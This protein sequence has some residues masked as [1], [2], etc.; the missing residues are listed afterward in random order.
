MMLDRFTQHIVDPLALMS[1]VLH[2]Q[3]YSQSSTTLPS[4]YVQSHFADNT[5]LDSGLSLTDNLIENLTNTL[6]LITQS[7]KTYLPQTNNQLRTSS[8][9]RN[10]ATVQDDRV[11]IQN[12]QG[13]QN[14]CQGNNARG[15]G[16]T[17][18]EKELHSVKLQLSSTI[19]HNKSMVV[20]I[21]LWYLDSSCSKHMMGDRSRLK[22]FMKKFIGTVRF[23]NDH[24]G[25]I[26]VYGDYVIGDS[27]ISGVY[28]VEGLGHNLFSVRQFCYFDLEVA[29]KIH[30]CYVR[31]SDGGELIKE[32]P[33][34]ERSVSPAPTVLVQINSAGTPSFTTDQDAPSL[35]HSPSSSALQ[36]PSLQQGIAA[37]YTHM[38]DNPLAPVDNDPFVNMFTTEPSSEASS[39]GDLNCVMLIALN[40]I[41]KVKLDEYD[42]VLKNK[43]RLAAKGYRQDEGIDFEESFTPDARIKAIRIFIANCMSI[44]SN[45]SHLFSPLRDPESL[46]RQRNLSEP[47]SLFDFKEVLN[48]NQNQEPPPQ[49]GLPPMKYF[50]PSMV[51]KLRN[52]IAKFEQKPYESLFEACEHYKLSIDRGPNHNMLLVT[53]INTLYNGLTLSH[54]DTI[55]AAAGGTFMQKTP[56]CP[57]VG[58]YNQETGYA[59]TGTCSLPSNTVPNPQEDLKAITTRSGVTLA[60]PSVSPSS[61]SKEVDREPEKKMDQ[62]LTRNTNNVLPLVVQPSPASTSFSNNSSSKIPEVTKDTVQPSTENIQPPV[63]QKQNIIYE[64][65]VAPKPKPTIPYPSRVNKQK[66]R[67]KD[68]NLALKFVEIFRNLHFEL[69]FADALLQMHLRV[70]L[71]LERPFLR[72]GRALIDVYGEELILRDNDEAI[73]FKEVL[74]FSDNSKSGNPTSISDPI[75]V[76]SS[77]SLTP[78]KGGDFILEEIE[79]CLTSESI[80]LR[81]DDTDLDLEGDIRLLEEL[82]KNDPSL[83]P[84]PSKEINK[85]IEAL[86]LVIPDWNLPF[87]LMCKASDFAIGAILGQR[88]MKHF[89]PIHY[90]SKTMTKAQIHYTMTEKEMLSVVYAFEKFWPY[91][92]LSKSIVYTDHSTLKYLFNKQD[93]KPRLIWC[94]L[95]LQEFYIIIHDKKRTKNL[96]AD[97]LSRLENPHK[98]V[99]R[100]THFCN[101]QFAKVRLKYGVTYRLSTAY[102]PQIIRK[103]EV[104]NQG[105]KRILER[106]VGENHASWSEK[107]DDDLWSFRTAYKT[108]IGCT[109]Y[110]LVYGKSFHLPIEL[111]H[112]A[113]WALK[114]ANFDLKTADDHRKLQLNKLNKLRDQA[115]NNSLI[116]KEKTKK[117]HDSSIKNRIFNV[118][119]RV[120]LFNSRLKIFSGKLKTYWTEPFT[121]AHVFPYGTIEL[122]QTDSLNFKVNGHRMKYYFGGEI[123]QLVILDL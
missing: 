92:V 78:F 108:P 48:N 112:K 66:L 68:D 118:G 98:D 87:E 88:K 40:W 119:D 19:N 21:V 76:L 58:G 27:V 83:S 71:I 8:N 117:L 123:P 46:I 18:Y 106:M 15:A 29:F 28:Y 95:L 61:S 70:P 34:V 12:V 52:E 42:D 44:R 63:A 62:V 5:Q 73:T 36:S 99:D 10:Q 2:P 122:S 72:T 110:K 103:I 4:T 81:I 84:L 102:H 80:P 51:T 31:D 55:N 121:I 47:S 56:E 111:E 24:F 74:G 11:V 59:T 100:G 113:Y 82:L 75:I 25:A 90:A 77:P 38:E 60:G 3:Y 7:Y 115:Y 86:I 6:A 14:I 120:L 41:Y 33:R 93:T 35:S 116:Y 97:H 104:L 109:P 30:S 101:E 16:A 85:L 89:Q 17:T 23:G 32:P 43:A 13:R 65:V 107:L 67:E 79:A 9:T 39:S 54:Q 53:Q 114:H 22:N 49:N 105:L 45:S 1:N 64:P 26:M 91:L 20:Q 37:K 57:A 50:P 96:A 94:V 69:S